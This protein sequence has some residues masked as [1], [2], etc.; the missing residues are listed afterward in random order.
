[1]E[2]LE[3]VAKVDEPMDWVNFIVIVEKP[4]SESIC[5]CIDPKSLNS[6]IKREHYWTKTIDDLLK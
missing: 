2:M 3:I 1:M 4:Q 5:I 6:A